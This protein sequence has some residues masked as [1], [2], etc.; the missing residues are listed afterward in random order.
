MLVGDDHTLVTFASTS[1][2]LAVT[3]VYELTCG[4]PLL[5]EGWLASLFKPPRLRLCSRRLVTVPFDVTVFRRPSS[6][7]A[8]GTSV[9]RPKL[10]FA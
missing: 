6:D 9:P 8:D 5:M 3:R 1:L 10:L 2:C 4:L 7:A